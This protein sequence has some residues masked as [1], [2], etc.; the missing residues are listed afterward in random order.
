MGVSMVI[1]TSPAPELVKH[2]P[3]RRQTADQK[4]RTFIT[5]LLRRKTRSG[6]AQ[7]LCSSCILS[8]GDGDA[9]ESRGSRLSLNQGVTFGALATDLEARSAPG[10]SESTRAQKNPRRAASGSPG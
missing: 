5:L 3:S 6:I 7:Q 2:D 4:I 10:L 1:V 8:P 9:R